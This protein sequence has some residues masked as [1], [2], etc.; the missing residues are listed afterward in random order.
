MMLMHASDLKKGGI[1]PEC[2]FWRDLKK[3]KACSWSNPSNK[4]A[5]SSRDAATLKE[6]ERFWDLTKEFH[7]TG[8]L[9][10]RVCYEGC[11]RRQDLDDIKW[12][13]FSLN[14]DGL[15]ESAIWCQKKN[16]VEKTISL[17][18]ETYVL[19]R[20]WRERQ[21]IVTGKAGDKIFM[22]ADFDHHHR[23]FRDLVRQVFK[24]YQGLA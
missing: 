19:A 23:F 15:Y 5:Q 18:S 16:K 4:G 10:L 8:W 13:S 21:P 17:H 3:S 2:A 7:P 9:M 22:G 11:L 14:K 24:Y 12:S 6:T 1:T 20:T